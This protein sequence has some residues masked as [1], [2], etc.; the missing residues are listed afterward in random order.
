VQVT[1]AAPT[2]LEAETLAKAALLAG[3]VSAFDVVAGHA[4]VLIHDGGEVVEVGA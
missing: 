3:P 4:A 1:V 2:A